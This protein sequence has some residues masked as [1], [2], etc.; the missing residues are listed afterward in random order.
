MAKAP[1]IVQATCPSYYF[2]PAQKSWCFGRSS[3]R[4]RWSAEGRPVDDEAR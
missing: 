3:D 4:L 1:A 2:H